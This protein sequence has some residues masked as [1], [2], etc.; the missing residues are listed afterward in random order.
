M[1]DATPGASGPAGVSAPA[2]LGPG[3]R[4]QSCAQAGLPV[5][6]L[7]AIVTAS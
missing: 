7:Y 6:R 3:R 5:P 4:G 2:R 1:G